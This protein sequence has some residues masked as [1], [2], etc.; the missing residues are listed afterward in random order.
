M[1]S[2][3]CK[4]CGEE[5]SSTAVTCRRCGMKV[6]RSTSMVS[7]VGTIIVVAIIYIASQIMIKQNS[8]EN[9]T[10]PDQNTTTRE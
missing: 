7:W 8:V 4:R 9:K 1:A 6:H 3:N 5:I 10:T 2:I